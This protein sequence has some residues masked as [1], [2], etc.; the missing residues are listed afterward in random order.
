[1][2]GYIRTFGEIGIADI[3]RVGE[4]NASPGE[5]FKHLTS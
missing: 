2:T 4:K 3:E 5:M 1:M